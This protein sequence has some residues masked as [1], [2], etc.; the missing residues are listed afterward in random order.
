MVQE[1]EATKEEKPKGVIQIGEMTSV[2]GIEYAGKTEFVIRIDTRSYPLKA[3]NQQ[4]AE[5]WVLALKQWY[6]FTKEQEE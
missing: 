1:E 3:E 6:A 4:V 2:G 5:A